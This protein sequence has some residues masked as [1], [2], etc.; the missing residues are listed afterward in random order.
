MKKFALVLVMAAAGLFAKGQSCPYTIVNNLSS[1]VKIAYDMIDPYPGPGYCGGS[2]TVPANSSVTLPPPGCPCPPGP[3]SASHRVYITVEEVG[4]AVVS[5]KQALFGP[6][7]YNG[8]TTDP[9]CSTFSH[10][11]TATQS[12]INP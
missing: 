2:I 7:T 11:Y 8:T 9:N 4:S 10:I 12:D 6:G 3:F 5:P 1:A